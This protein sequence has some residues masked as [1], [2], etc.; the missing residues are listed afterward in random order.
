MI[1]EVLISC[2]DFLYIL[3]QTVTFEQR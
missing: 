3:Y 2:D 1:G